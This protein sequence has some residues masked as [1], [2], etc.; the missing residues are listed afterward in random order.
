[1]VPKSYC[2]VIRPKLYLQGQ[3]TR[4]ATQGSNHKERSGHGFC[5]LSDPNAWPCHLS[6]R[7][8]PLLLT[9][10]SA[11]FPTHPI[12]NVLLAL[13]VLPKPLLTQLLFTH[14]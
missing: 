8:R 11:K 12:W 10:A 14:T 4:L 7:Q 6:V 3:E 2:M 5:C 13:I 9:Q 1:M